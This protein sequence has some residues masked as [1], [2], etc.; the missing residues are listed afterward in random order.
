M[1]LNDIVKLNDNKDIYYALLEYTQKLAEKKERNDSKKKLYYVSAEFLIGKLLSNNLINLGIY[2][3]VKLLLKQNGKNLSDIEMLEPEPSLGNGGLGRLA[4]CFLDSVATL[5]LSGDG[6]GLNYH[7]GLF[8]Q[9]FVQNFQTTI[10]DPWI[11]DR[12]WL[13][14]TDKTY[15]ICFGNCTV[16][17][18]LYDIY[19]TGYE[20]RTNRLHLFDAESVDETVVAEG[21]EFD[22][23]VNN[24]TKRGT[25]ALLSKP[26]SKVKVY[27]ICTDE[28]YMI[29]Q[30]TAALV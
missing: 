8:R 22:K 17:S 9:K 30:D 20:N 24:S 23:E 12:S 19:V 29:A 28:E 18:R 4:A 25:D 26:E 21:I 1:N 7:Y 6:I 3:E 2:D 27:V 11:E 10:P 13:V 16:T 14:K 15:E 5:G